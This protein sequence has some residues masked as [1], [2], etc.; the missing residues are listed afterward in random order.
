MI[1]GMI[2][3][4]YPLHHV[5]EELLVRKAKQFSKHISIVL[6]QFWCRLPVDRVILSE[7]DWRPVIKRIRSLYQY[8]HLYYIGILRD[9]STRKNEGSMLR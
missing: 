4:N 6:T 5:M 8:L 7:P 2:L 9:R 3:R 1:K